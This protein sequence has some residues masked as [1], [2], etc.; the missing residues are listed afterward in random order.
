MRT[1]EIESRGFPEQVAFEQVLAAMQ[2]SRS[3]ILHFIVSVGWRRR[4]LIGVPMLLLPAIGFAVGQFAP[5]TF[6]TYM[7]LLVQEPAKLNPYLGDSAV[8]T[9]L[10][11]RMP[12]IT[13][14]VRNPSGL[15]HVALALAESRPNAE[16]DPG[17]GHPQAVA[18]L[19]IQL[20]GSDSVELRLSG[21][22]EDVLAEELAA[23]GDASS[24]S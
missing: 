22:K 3:E 10:Q 6:V 20:I 14:L 12:V 2:R 24:T 7:T 1:V 11:E 5:R 16:A 15:E 21:D 4:F 13:S 17:H 9:R 18:G 23:I 19:T 8:G